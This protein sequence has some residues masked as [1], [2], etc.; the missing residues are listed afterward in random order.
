MI[1]VWL[2][3][4]IILLFGFVVVLGGPPYLPTKRRQIDAALDLLDLRPGQTLLELGSGDG[5]VVAAA[6]K[7]GW[8][9]VGIELN[10]LLVLISRAYTWRY[11][12]QVRIIWGDI[13]RVKWPQSDGI[14]AFLLPRLMERLDKNIVRWHKKPVYLASFAFVVPGKKP[15]AQRHGV[16]L[17]LYR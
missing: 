5:R 13:F 1:L 15:E 17:Y 10:P 9:V 12:K 4:V 8:K 11:R 2:V 7:R 14:F 3:A 16:F 6:A